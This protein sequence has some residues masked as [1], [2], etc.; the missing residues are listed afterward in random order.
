[1]ICRARADKIG[2]VKAER[3]IL[4]FA[5]VLEYLGI[6]RGLLFKLMAEG[7]LPFAK[8]GRRTLFR[9]SDVDAFLEKRLVKKSAPAGARTS[10]RKAAK[11]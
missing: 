2:G 10:A 11:K 1:L 7:D 6:G 4:S 8:L 5:D 3:E 9:K